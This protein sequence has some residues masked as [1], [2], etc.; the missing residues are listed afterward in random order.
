MRF[1]K[2]KFLFGI[3]FANLNFLTVSCCCCCCCC[4]AAVGLRTIFYYQVILQRNGLLTARGWQ[5]GGGV[6][7][8]KSDEDMEGICDSKFDVTGS[9][10]GLVNILGE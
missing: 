6:I 9:T 1:T 2:K 3:L 4:Y 10:L 5:A 7:Q 8:I